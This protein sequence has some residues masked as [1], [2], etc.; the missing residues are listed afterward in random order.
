MIGDFLVVFVRVVFRVADIVKAGIINASPYFFRD[1]GKVYIAV[2]VGGIPLSF[3]ARRAGTINSVD[4]M[5]VISSFR[6]GATF[7]MI[8]LMLVFVFISVSS[9]S[10]ET[11]VACS[12]HC[13][14]RML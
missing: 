5:A 9:S 4:L 14:A 10:P 7:G 11:C 13:Y 12:W 3:D 6:A 8:P 1:W 2:F